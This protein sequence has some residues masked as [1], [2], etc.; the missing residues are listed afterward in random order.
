MEKEM[1]DGAMSPDI[2]EVNATP[3]VEA[4]VPEWREQGKDLIHESKAPL[5]PRLPLRTR[6]ILKA[7]TLGSAALAACGIIGEAK[8]TQIHPT[9]SPTGLGGGSTEVLPTATAT[10]RATETAKPTDIP[11]YTEAEIKAGNPFDRATFPTRFKKC[12]DAP[13]TCTDQEL[14]NYHQFL[15]AERE[16]KGIAR[17]AEYKDHINLDLQ[18][19][20]NGVKWMLE[21]P[22]EVKEGMLALEIDS[23]EMRAMIEEKNKVIEWYDQAG[24]KTYIY[25]FDKGVELAF[26]PRIFYKSETLGSILGMPNINAERIPYDTASGVFSGVFRLGDTKIISADMKGK[27]NYH[28]LFGAAIFKEGF[29]LPKG[30]KCMQLDKRYDLVYELPT[31][32]ALGPLVSANNGNVIEWS[33]LYDNFGEMILVHPYNAE[34][35][36][37]IPGYTRPAPDCFSLNLNLEMAGQIGFYNLEGISPPWTEK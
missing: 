37:K 13:L 10:S 4:R 25:G 12:A 16:D 19:V 6:V 26:S 20:W 1:A 9:S 8:P 22:K 28:A 29:I 33:T 24:D 23:F 18:S 27:D 15:L 34:L 21:H 32:I 11:I 17:T 35:R 3:R 14:Q 36:D 7:I 2:G 30:T 5:R 31:D